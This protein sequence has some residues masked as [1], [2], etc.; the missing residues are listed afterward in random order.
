V[1]TIGLYH[2]GRTWLHRCPAGGKLAALVVALA[3]TLAY[4]I[5]VL[6]PTVALFALARIPPRLVL[7]SVRP[8]WPLLVLTG[9]LQLVT[10]GPLR[11]A[12]VLCGLV[13][14]VLL[15]ALVTLTTRV[16]DMLTVITAVLRPLRRLGV[17]PE[18]VAL[19]LAL[20]IRCVPMLTAIVA[21]AREAQLARG[22]GRNPLA[23]AV[24]VVV[25]ALRAAD[26]LGEALTAR[27]LDD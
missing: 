1:T 19:L 23:L 16:T 7:A 25:R 26:A 11:A 9:V 21:A 13:G 12:S 5:L 10:A 20:T 24:P 3:L 17:H 8:L 2:P 18:R 6:G 27:G 15:A 4:P 22:A 14:G